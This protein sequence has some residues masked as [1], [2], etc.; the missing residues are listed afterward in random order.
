MNI[1]RF[2]GMLTALVMTVSA[3][4]CVV[5]AFAADTAE[6]AEGNKLIAGNVSDKQLPFLKFELAGD[7]VKLKFD[8][9]GGGGFLIPYDIMILTNDKFECIG[10]KS[11]E[12]VFTPKG[13]GKY[14]I[15][16]PKGKPDP[17]YRGSFGEILKT[18]Y[19]IML[20][21][22]HDNIVDIASE[23]M[24][25]MVSDMVEAIIYNHIVLTSLSGKKREF[26]TTEDI[27]EELVAELM[28]GFFEEED[29]ILSYAYSRYISPMSD[30]YPF[31]CLIK[32]DAEKKY[33][34]KYYLTDMITDDVEY[35]N[36]F[37]HWMEC[38]EIPAPN[39]PEKKIKIESVPLVNDF[40][41]NYDESKPQLVND[42]FVTDADG[43]I[44]KKYTIRHCNFF[45]YK[46]AITDKPAE[47]ETVMLPENDINC[48]GTFSV[49]DAVMLQKW[50]HGLGGMKMYNALQADVCKDE[51]IDVFDLC[52]LKTELLKAS[53]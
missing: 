27:E 42:Y 22:C 53:A 20:I 37:I 25:S 36:E 24:Y 30:A 34:I 43:N 51:V 6:K 41:R 28:C 11:H 9:C 12:C 2:I 49:A 47:F 45:G 1:R 31:E 46:A 15:V 19:N 4:F 8:G 13:D 16:C 50:L 48:D 10:E 7:S 44:I 39:D 18:D 35:M 3:L 23:N 5:P 26:K 38:I 33:Q 52:R 29:H 17:E 21:E 40:K 14:M 32:T